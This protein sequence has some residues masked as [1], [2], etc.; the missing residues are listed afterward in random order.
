MCKFCCDHQLLSTRVLLITHTLRNVRLTTQTKLKS[1]TKCPKL[2]KKGKNDGQHMHFFNIVK[3]KRIQARC[4]AL[5]CYFLLGS[6]KLEVK[7]NIKYQKKKK[8]KKQ[9]S[10]KQVE[11]RR[12]PNT[13][14][15][16]YDL[17]SLI[18]NRK[19]SLTKSRWEKWTL[20]T[21][22]LIVTLGDKSSW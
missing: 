8:K 19:I 18:F 16:N 5:Q 4:V 10:E 9:Q 17:F 2:G 7:R 1:Y 12:C 14:N 22:I 20:D 6:T 21:S 13:L 15:P 3:K 11:R